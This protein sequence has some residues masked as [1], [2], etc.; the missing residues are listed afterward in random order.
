V[1]T[2][3]PVY[4]KHLALL[5]KWL[6]QMWL[7]ENGLYEVKLEADHTQLLFKIHQTMDYL[8]MKKEY[9]PTFQNKCG[10]CT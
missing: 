2:T 1:L 4:H 5:V 9:N 3:K 8:K 7:T 6:Q 10:Y